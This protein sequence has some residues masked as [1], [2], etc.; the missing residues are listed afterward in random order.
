[1]AS[2]QKQYPKVGSLPRKVKKQFLNKSPTT[3]TPNSCWPDRAICVIRG[4]ITIT[5][6]T[7]LLSKVTQEQSS[8]HWTSPDRS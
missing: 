4:R 7:I 8:C 6:N 1:M 3:L 2:G 5:G